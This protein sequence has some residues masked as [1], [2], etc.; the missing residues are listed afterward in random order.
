MGT[1]RPLF[2]HDASTVVPFPQRVVAAGGTGLRLRKWTPSRVKVKKTVSYLDGIRPHFPL[3]VFA[4]TVENARVCVESRVLIATPTPEDGAMGELSR[5]SRKLAYRV[6]ARLGRPWSD[7]QVLAWIAKLPARK[8]VRY[9]EAFLSLRERPFEPADARVKCFI[10]IEQTRIKEGKFPKPRMIQF[11]SARYLVHVARYIKP[12][13]HCFYQSTGVFG[14]GQTCAKNMNNATRG[15]KLVELCRSFADSDFLALDGASFDAHVNVPLLKLEHG[16][17]AAMAKSAGWAQCDISTMRRVLRMQLKNQVSGRF[18]DGTVS[19]TVTGNRMSGDLNTALGNCVIMSCMTHFAFDHEVGQGNWR[20]L[21]DGDDCSVIVSRRHC[22]SREVGA[23]LDWY[24]KFGMDMRLDGR[25]SAQDP[26]C[27]EFCQSH[28]VSVGGDWRMVRDWEKVLA[29]TSSGVN[30]HLTIGGFRTYAGAVG[31]GDGI[32][33]E[34]IPV[35]QEWA[36]YL[37][38]VAA[39]RGPLRDPDKTTM[40]WRFQEIPV[41]SLE[42]VRVVEI[43]DSTRSSFARAFGI[44]PATQAR[45]EDMIRAL[46]VETPKIRFDH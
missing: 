46:P 13:E 6:G 28:P 45:L 2:E 18:P 22:G 21:D 23:V 37:R 11:R 16:F 15:R 33:N 17:Y 10:K 7:D 14:P 25:G 9:N 44:N 27:V 20:M 35:L 3:R 31:I 1:D 29:T 4:G 24:G 32:L 19:Y 39:V 43:L 40:E 12:I 41:L 36:N 38:K 26:E 30:W 8:R 42:R 5:A 34:G